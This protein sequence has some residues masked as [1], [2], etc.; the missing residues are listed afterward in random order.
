MRSERSYI[1]ETEARSAITKGREPNKIEPLGESFAQLVRS[2][3]DSGRDPLELPPL[4]RQY[5]RLRKKISDYLKTG[6]K[7]EEFVPDALVA[8]LR[9]LPEFTSY[10][11]EPEDF[12]AQLGSDFAT[13]S[14]RAAMRLIIERATVLRDQVLPEVVRYSQDFYSAHKDTLVE[15]VGDFLHANDEQRRILRER[16][17]DLQIA[18]IDPITGALERIG[19]LYSPTQRRMGIA[20]AS[21]SLAGVCT[22]ELIHAL[23][24]HLSA[25]ITE[26]S[27]D[28]DDDDTFEIIVNAR[29]GISFQSA[30]GMITK[31]NF[32]NEAVTEFLAHSYLRAQ[33]DLLEASKP[34]PLQR[35]DAPY[36][37]DPYVTPGY[38]SEVRLLLY[39]HA[40][41]EITP[42]IRDG[43]DRQEL[44]AARDSA[45]QAGVLIDEF[46][47]DEL[48][49]Q[50]Y[51]FDGQL[52]GA[53]GRARHWRAWTGY[54]R[55]LYGENVLSQ[56]DTLWHDAHDSQDAS[57]TEEAL[58][59]SKRLLLKRFVERWGST[60]SAD[61]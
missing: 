59:A 5:A 57:L 27:E 26:R 8:S 56:L 49:F 46:A 15:Y 45:V 24:S 7:G 4:K 42:N 22:H 25:L 36:S 13:I 41:H 38:Q 9:K 53:Q 61:E 1:P 21:V 19:G 52:P 23:S 28:D 18:A 40:P 55:E 30:R 35:E 39:L 33:M 10:P 12:R 2:F 20:P 34:T 32:L 51:F 50:A 44:A 6:R 60:K 17:E 3:E 29:T 16:L 31:F 58:E 37:D 47:A 54:M 14:D 43:V 48:L 11:E